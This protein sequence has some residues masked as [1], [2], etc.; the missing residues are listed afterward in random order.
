ML[1][2]LLLTLLLA[3][4]PAVHAQP[5]APID[6]AAVVA[7]HQVRN[8]SIN[9]ESALTI[10]N[11]DFALTLDVTGLQGL[12]RIYYDNGLPLETRNSWSWHSFPNPDNLR[13]EDTLAPAPFHG[14]QILYPTQQHTPAGRYY[15][16]NPQPMPLGQFAFTLHGE[17]LRTEDIAGI[18]QTLDLW[19]GIVTSRLLVRGQPLEVVT[20]THGSAAVLAV[21][22]RSPLI[23]SG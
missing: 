10:G 17:P 2:R 11:G 12:E 3:S 5:T 9:P 4:A 19:T 21:Q 18:N 7:R 1:A 14:R 22:A 23:A 13:F 15:R 6:R 8:T 16:E 20:A